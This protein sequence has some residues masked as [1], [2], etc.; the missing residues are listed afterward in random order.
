M[1]GLRER[2]DLFYISP[3]RRHLFIELQCKFAKD[4]IRAMVKNAMILIEIQIDRAWANGNSGS[5]RGD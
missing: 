3:A 1:G 4:E 5:D 2:V